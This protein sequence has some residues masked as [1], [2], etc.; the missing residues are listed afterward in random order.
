LAERGMFLATRLPLLTGLFAD[1]WL[2][3]LLVNPDVKEMRADIHQ[4]S[5]VSGYTKQNVQ[6]TRNSNFGKFKHHRCTVD[7]R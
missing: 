2:S 4:F 5:A 1:A 6:S 3:Q 7:R